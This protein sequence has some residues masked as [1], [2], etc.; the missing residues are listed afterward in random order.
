MVSHV[1]VWLS[2]RGSCYDICH[3]PCQIVLQSAEWPG[4]GTLIR[5]IVFLKLTL[6]CLRTRSRRV[7]TRRPS[8]HCRYLEAYVSGGCCRGISVTGS[9]ITHLHGG[10]GSTLPPATLLCLQGV[11]CDDIDNGQEITRVD[12]RALGVTVGDVARSAVVTR[13]P[14]SLPGGRGH[15]QFGGDHAHMW[16]TPT[17][18]WVTLLP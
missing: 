5:R 14:C 2:H 4:H 10:G 18:T 6:R 12:S 11:L 3:L 1:A 16:C 7:P 9:V 17:H 15:D 8:A 13:N